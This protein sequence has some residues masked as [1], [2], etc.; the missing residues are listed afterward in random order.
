M[1]QT[2]ETIGLSVE[3]E[4]SAHLSKAAAQA[5]KSVMEKGIDHAIVLCDARL[6]PGLRTLLGRTIQRLPV[7]AYDE[8][9]PGSP[10]E[11][12]D[13]IT[14]PDGLLSSSAAEQFSMV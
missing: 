10:L 1:T 2:A 11:P 12:C 4:L 13:M 7:A 5:W 6:R 14:L 3:P 8:I 9:V